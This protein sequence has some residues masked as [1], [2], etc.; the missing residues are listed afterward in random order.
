MAQNQVRIAYGT[1]NGMKE[2]IFQVD[3]DDS[4]SDVLPS[5]PSRLEKEKGLFSRIF[6]KK[7]SRTLSRHDVT[8]TESE[9]KMKIQTANEGLEK[10]KVVVSKT[11]APVVHQRA[12]AP[13]LLMLAKS[14]NCGL[15]EPVPALPREEFSKS[16]DQMREAVA[17]ARKIYLEELDSLTAGTLVTLLTASGDILKACG[18]TEEGLEYLLEAVQISRKFP[19][20][21]E[22]LAG[23]LNDVGLLY[24]DIKE[25]REAKKSLMESHALLLDLN[26]DVHPD[27]AVSAG[28]LGIAYSGCKE[29]SA[30]SDMIG[31][32]IKAMEAIYGKDHEYTLQQR[33][34]LGASLITAGDSSEARKELRAVISR[35]NQLSIY[36]EEHPF[37]LYLEQEYQTAQETSS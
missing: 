18:K 10:P 12:D 23:I 29:N 4:S 17:D 30:S 16:L 20:L 6:K 37:L 32:A 27:V 31:N 5:Q 25:F 26:G 14:L 33:G 8:R 7:K 11:K 13:L 28:N 3:S 1:S 9:V 34:L 22:N 15:R 35:L 24:Y 21:K 2:Q 19:I 36:P